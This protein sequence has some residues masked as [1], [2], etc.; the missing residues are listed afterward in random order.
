MLTYFCDWLAKL[1]SGSASFL[2]SLAGSSIGLIALL[3]GAFVNAFLNRRRDDRLR[4]EDRLALAST[5]FAELKGIHRTL[6]EN[7]EHLENNPPDPD[8]GFVVPQPSMK[9]LSDVLPKIGLLRAE[10]IR[11]V[12]DAYV[13]TEQYLQGLILAGG[14][15]QPNMPEGRDMVLMDAERTQ[16]VIEFNRGR[17]GAVQEASNAL[18]PYL[19]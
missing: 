9:L 7:A 13:L 16:F 12:M 15:L 1:P 10:T 11:K 19:K 2:G 18:A 6:I 5:L 14:T 4:E 17:A 3:I 8:G